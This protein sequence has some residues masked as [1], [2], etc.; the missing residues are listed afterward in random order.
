M[1]NTALRPFFLDFGL[2]PTF[3][4]WAQITMLHI[5]MLAIRLRCFPPTAA[6]TWQQQL[7]D[8]F[9][10]DAEDR[11]ARLHNIGMRSARSKFLKA[12]YEQYRGASAA[13]DQGLVKG[14]AV[15]ATALWRNVWSGREDV[16]WTD[17]AMTVGYVR[18]VLK[19]LDALPDD[20]VAS[21]VVRFGEVLNQ[22]ELVERESIGMTDGTI[23]AGN[24][25]PT[26]APGR[27][28][29]SSSLSA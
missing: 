14:D 1:K 2:Q 20:V 27:E 7:I 12:L 13:Y 8:H 5:H 26:T 11:M 17:I 18:R 21:G 28:Q 25:A 6:Q 23:P 16:R 9:F 4:N 15:L 24:V 10:T 22:R 3:S 19:G 29:A